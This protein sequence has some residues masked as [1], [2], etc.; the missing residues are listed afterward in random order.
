MKSV[1][2]RFG[3]GVG[4]VALAAACLALWTC[5]DDAAGPDR[6]ALDPF[7]G[8]WYA[9]QFEF[10]PI[11]TEIPVSVDLVQR[12]VALTLEVEGDGRFLIAQGTP[13]GEPSIE[14]GRLEVDR[15]SARITLVFDESEP[16]TGSY[17]FNH[18][19]TILTLGLTGARFDFN[20]DGETVPA[21]VQVVLEKDE[22]FP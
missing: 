4:L 19:G 8:T 14:R 5:S 2:R 6:E 16:V 18:D 3:T 12:G 10:K 13:G 9:S 21:R 17:F 11:T 15:Q 22:L 1:T 7:L 20:E